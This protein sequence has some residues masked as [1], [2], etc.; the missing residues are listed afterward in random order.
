MRRGIFDFTAAPTA[1]AKTEKK[2]KYIV[3]I[4]SKEDYFLSKIYIYI[5][6]FK[7]LILTVD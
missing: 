4:K 6:L 1:T 5:I 7:E 2:M 3:K